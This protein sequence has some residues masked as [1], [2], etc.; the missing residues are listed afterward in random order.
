MLKTVIVS[1]KSLLPNW[2]IVD[3]SHQLIGR[4][5]SQIAGL[6]LNKHLK[7]Y[8]SFLF[9]ITN[10]IIINAEKISISGNKL[11]KKKYLTYSGYQSGLH[12]KT[13]LHLK[14]LNIE[15]LF[16]YT[17]HGML[18]K[19]R[20]GKAIFSHLYIFSKNSHTHQAQCPIFLTLV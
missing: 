16:R 9:P 11:K 10:I 19:N 12:F 2:Y 13:F 15:K 8:S 5:S 6:L 7:I 17:I 4:F 14:L 18:P 20:L 1:Q 3:A